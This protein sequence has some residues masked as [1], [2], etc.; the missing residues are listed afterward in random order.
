[1]CEPVVIIVAVSIVL[2]CAAVLR[3]HKFHPEKP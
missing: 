3:I 2:D 1:M